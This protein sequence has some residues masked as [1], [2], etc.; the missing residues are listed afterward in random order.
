MKSQVLK[1]E[2]KSEAA[3]KRNLKKVIKISFKLCLKGF[4][5]SYYEKTYYKK[6]NFYIKIMLTK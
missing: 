2:E 6:K 4:L 1:E 3:R 5:L